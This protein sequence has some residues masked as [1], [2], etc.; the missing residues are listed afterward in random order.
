MAITTGMKSEL[1][2]SYEQR[3]EP[4]INTSIASLLTGTNPINELGIPLFEIKDIPRKGKCL[5]ARFNIS[6]G[7]RILCEKPV[8][9]A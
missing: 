2:R 5:I 3:D 9:T 8:L 7:T 1:I 6:N 4:E